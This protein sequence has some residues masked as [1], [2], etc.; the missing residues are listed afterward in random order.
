MFLR[1]KNNRTNA[2]ASTIEVNQPKTKMI[3]YR[4]RWTKKPYNLF[5]LKEK[6]DLIIH[7]AFI[8]F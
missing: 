4:N 7:F 3:W 1:K 8:W 5:G 6:N 2:I